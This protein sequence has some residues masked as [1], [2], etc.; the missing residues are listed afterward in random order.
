[1]PL[2][3][4]N[5]LVFFVEPTLTRRI[6]HAAGFLPATVYSSESFH[7]ARSK[8]QCTRRQPVGTPSHITRS[9]TFQ[10]P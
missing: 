1:M 4:L 7:M 9:P 2:V 8:P 6:E 10:S 3:V 5:W